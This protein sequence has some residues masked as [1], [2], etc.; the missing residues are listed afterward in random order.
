MKYLISI[1]WVAIPVFSVVGYILVLGTKTCPAWLLY[2][3]GILLLFGAAAWIFITLRLAAFKKRLVTFFKSL[4]EG[5][6]KTGIAITATVK[7]EVT[8]ISE[9]TNKVAEQLLTYDL[10]REDLVALNHRT[11]KLILQNIDSSVILADLEKKSFQLNPAAQTFFDIGHE[12]ESFDSI[13]SNKANEAF[14][15]IFESVTTDD[16]IVT[17]GQVTVYLTK[18]EAKHDVSVKIVPVKDTD[19]NV[20][21]AII[22][23]KAT[24]TVLIEMSV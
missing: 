7:D 3:N 2:V 17:E 4:L 12:T 10:L 11:I 20:R 18:S 16:K 21:M 19:E 14:W 15:K 5:K 8:Q 23:L 6:Y 22:I 24:D 13:Q 1:L 9:L